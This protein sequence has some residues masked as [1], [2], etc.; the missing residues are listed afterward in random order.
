MA[1]Q[2]IPIEGVSL[3]GASCLVLQDMRA[4]HLLKI[5]LNF[6]SAN[7]SDKPEKDFAESGTNGG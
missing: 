2:D 1:Y 6:R 4:K 5:L 3:N 7:F